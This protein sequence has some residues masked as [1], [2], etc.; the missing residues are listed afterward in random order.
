MRYVGH[1]QHATSRLLKA[2]YDFWLSP[3]REFLAIVGGGKMA[4]VPVNS[5]FFWSVL[6]DG[7]ILTTINADS[8]ADPDISGRTE[9]AL[10]PGEGFE[11]LGKRHWA[12]VMAAGSPCERFT[13]DNPLF[14]LFQ[15][16]RKKYDRW[17]ALGYCRFLDSDRNAYRLTISGAFRYA[18]LSVGRAYRRQLSPDRSP[19]MG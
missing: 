16:R 19:A 7:R 10:F 8:A 6:Q 2:R 11:L 18:L 4:S 14:D 1:L 9:E 3:G 12:R 17:E 13:A 15:L 5:L